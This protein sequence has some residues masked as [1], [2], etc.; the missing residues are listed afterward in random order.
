MSHK[1]ES[2]LK[3]AA[4]GVIAGGLAFITVKSVCSRRHFKRA[5]AAKAFKTIGTL[6]DSF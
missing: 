4:A 6:L 5:S 3:G 1:T 2:V